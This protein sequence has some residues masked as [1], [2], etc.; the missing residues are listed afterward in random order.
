[1]LVAVETIYYVI[2]AL[3]AIT[4]NQ[5][6]QHK[7]GEPAMKQSSAESIIRRVTPSGLE[8]QWEWKG[9]PW[10][11]RDCH[12][13]T[14]PHFHPLGKMGLNRG[15]TL[16]WIGRWWESELSLGL[17]WVPGPCYSK[18]VHAQQQQRRLGACEKYSISGLAPTCPVRIYI[19]KGSAGDWWAQESLG[20]TGLVDAGGLDFRSCS[21][22]AVLQAAGS[23]QGSVSPSALLVYSENCISYVVHAYTSYFFVPDVPRSCY[24]KIQNSFGSV[25]DSYQLLIIILY[26][27]QKKYTNV[28]EKSSWIKFF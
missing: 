17:V 16:E 5:Q 12:S 21:F 2:L 8:G 3:K 11:L 7:H 20:S 1:M 22:R 14:Y 15:N 13:H 19:L 6:H 24:D 4:M 27:F 28:E 26:V 18:C 23:F 10:D 25:S 9:N